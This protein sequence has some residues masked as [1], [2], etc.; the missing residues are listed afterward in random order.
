VDLLD[1]FLTPHG[2]D[3]RRISELQ[4]TAERERRARRAADRDQD[5]QIASLAADNDR[6][7][8]WVAALTEVLFAKGALTDQELREAVQ[9]LQPPP[10]P[11]EEENPFAGLGQ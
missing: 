10:P 8:L 6:L 5:E 7:R 11:A 1:F 9:R 4:E 3:A 2:R